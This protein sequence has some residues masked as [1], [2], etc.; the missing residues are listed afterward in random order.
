MPAFFMFEF[1]LPAPLN[2]FYLKSLVHQTYLF[3]SYSF[4]VFVI[5][6]H[7]RVAQEITP[8]QIIIRTA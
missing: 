3:S 1:I 7:Y 2:P 5:F 8:D 6:A 4:Y